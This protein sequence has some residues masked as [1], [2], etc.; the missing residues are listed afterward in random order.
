M[1]ASL[2]GIKNLI[3]SDI[4]EKAIADTKQNLAWVAQKFPNF[5][6]GKLRAGEF[7]ISNFKLFNISATE[8]SQKIKLNSVDAIVT[9]PY[10]GPQRGNP[11]PLK[12]KNDLEKLYSAA[13]R[14]FKKI[15]K[16]D[17]RVVMIFPVRAEG[18][19]PDF[20]F[21]NPNL[22]GWQVVNS[23]PEGLQEKLHTTRRGTIVYGRSGQ[24]VYR[25]IIVF[26][27]I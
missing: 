9:E 12:T 14:E 10:L 8:I 16:P 7:P 26:K 4:S 18:N 1:E 17:G 27:K 21:M 15:L 24:K 13:L 20:H 6:F 22:V 11:D 25:E 2:M 5:P 23:L 19:R 3:G